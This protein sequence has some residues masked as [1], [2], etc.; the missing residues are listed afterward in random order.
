MKMFQKPSE[1]ETM[2]ENVGLCLTFSS[3]RITGGLDI[4]SFMEERYPFGD[5]TL[6]KVFRFFAV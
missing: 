1:L 5:I 3:Q 4:A 6:L 2:R